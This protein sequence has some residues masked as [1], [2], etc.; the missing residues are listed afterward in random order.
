MKQ[1]SKYALLTDGI[2]LFFCFCYGAR[3]IFLKLMEPN[4]LTKREMEE[5]KKR[6]EHEGYSSAWS[7]I[8]DGLV[9]I[10]FLMK[11]YYSQMTNYHDIDQIL[12]DNYSGY[13]GEQYIDMVYYSDAYME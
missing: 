6:L 2:Q 4:N 5:R 1:I 12:E 3:I 7:I 9:I 10:F 11:F 13:K 8:T